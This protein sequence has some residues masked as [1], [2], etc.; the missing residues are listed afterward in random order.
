ML[1]SACGLV[2]LALY[3]RL[4]AIL[5]RI[6][7]FHQ[8]KLGLLD[9][10]DEQDVDGQNL[11]LDMLD[12]QIKGVISKARVIQKSLF[13]MLAAISAFLL[14]SL[15]AGAT[16]LNEWFGIAVVGTSVLGIALFLSGIGL[17]MRELSLSLTPLEEEN[18]YLES[19]KVHRLAKQKSG[20]HLKIA[21][22]A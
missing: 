2:T 15:F 6:R 16:V 5:A 22:S 21:K 7:A 14:C 12:S 13:C 19:V 9:C 18:A 3:N 10:L 20:R 4:G 1:I 11:L 8:Q 17:A